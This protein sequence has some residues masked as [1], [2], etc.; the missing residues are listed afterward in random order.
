MCF[1]TSFE[2][3]KDCSG[4]VC[5]IM[6]KYEVVYNVSDGRT[7]ES[8]T[9]ESGGPGP[10]SV[11]RTAS[12]YYHST[13]VRTV[14]WEWPNPR[15]Y[16][17]I[18]S[19]IRFDK[20]Q[21]FL[22]NYVVICDCLWHRDH[23]DIDQTSI[24]IDGS[25]QLRSGS[26][27]HR[28]YRPEKLGHMNIYMRKPVDHSNRRD[29]ERYRFPVARYD[30]NRFPLRGPFLSFMPQIPL[31]VDRLTQQTI[32]FSPS[33]VY[34]LPPVINFFGRRFSIA[35][36]IASGYASLVSSGAP[37]TGPINMMPYFQ[38]I[39]LYGAGIPTIDSFT[40]GFRGGIRTKH[41]SFDIRKQEREYVDIE[42]TYETEEDY[43]EETDS[44]EPPYS[45]HEYRKSPSY[46]YER[47]RY[48]QT[49][50]KHTTKSTTPQIPV[51]N[52]EWGP[53]THP[54]LI[55]TPAECGLLSVPLDYNRPQ[56]TKIKI[57]V[58]RIKH[59][60]LDD[61][62]QGVMLLN[63]GGPG[64]SGLPLVLIV[65]AFPIEVSQTYDF[66]G[67]D[68]RGVGSSEPAVRCELTS[69]KDPLPEP[70]PSTQNLEDIWLN[71]TE[72]F[73]SNCAKNNKLLLPYM[74][75]VD[76]AKDM[77][78]IR[79][80]LGQE[81]INYYGFSAG[82]YLG[83]IYATLYPTRVRRMVLDSSIDPD[84]VW[85]PANLRLPESIN[86]NMEIFFR[87][88]A[89]HTNVYR[90]GN[91]KSEVEFQWFKVR[92][93]LEGN[94]INGIIGPYEWANLFSPVAYTQESWLTFG[95]A[96]SEL[97]NENNATLIVQLYLELIAQQGNTADASSFTMCTDAPS[98]RNWEKVRLDFW[99]V[100]PQAPITTWPIAWGSAPCLYWAKNGHKS[101]IV[102]GEDIGDILLVI[103]TLD[104]A[105]PLNDSLKVR[106]LFPHARL[107]A[108]T[109]GTT[110]AS[111]L[112]GNLCVD[113][114]IIT[115]FQSGNVPPRQN[116][117]VADVICSPLPE[118][119]PASRMAAQKQNKFRSH[120]HGHMHRLHR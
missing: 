20:K 82:T 16:F 18:M 97:V 94:P 105:L 3:Y 22:Y 39:P 89:K 119:S 84:K 46:R 52:I 11:N 78:S 2:N 112:R 87:W 12:C 102:N 10:N 33:G 38:P 45:E 103:Q 92:N 25:P 68:P 35:D 41:R 36:L 79:L 13:K 23:T 106:E 75:T 55:Q 4:G 64:Q 9:I 59:T 69:S 40:G 51:S 114:V 1:V 28:E 101:V 73:A 49:G 66:I 63:P 113:N 116:G 61:N 27:Y 77:E 62:F 74:T 88:I 86:R 15:I 93:Q 6:R 17:T 14:R 117:N 107:I 80:A 67:F 65:Q 60:V 31:F 111:S 70:I 110:H 34:I 76:T 37:P 99:R 50:T 47:P 48:H 53:C 42:S 7:I 118:P 104:P 43:D 115:Y 100:Y 81:Q 91:T 71:I 30:R 72:T 44:E 56:G 90:L 21:I 32:I 95:A 120:L 8:T 83:Q 96:L 58:S 29:F 54:A 19:I 85:Y 109:N 108:V 24:P 57:A 5:V 98:P 26:S